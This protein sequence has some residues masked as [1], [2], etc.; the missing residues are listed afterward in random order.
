MQVLSKLVEFIFSITA[1]NKKYNRLTQAN[2]LINYTELY[3]YVRDQSSY[4]KNVVISN[5]KYSLYD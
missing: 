3:P 4:N 1:L 5:F 2:C